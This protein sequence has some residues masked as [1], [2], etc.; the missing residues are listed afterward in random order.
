MTAYRSGGAFKNANLAI[1]TI[2]RLIYSPHKLQLN[3]VWS[4]GMMKV[5]L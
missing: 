4:V 2:Q 3:V 1:A 5:H